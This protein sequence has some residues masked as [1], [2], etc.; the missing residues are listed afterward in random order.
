MIFGQDDNTTT[1]GNSAWDDET[2]G[3][4]REA[5]ILNGLSQNQR[6]KTNIYE[7][8][9]SDYSLARPVEIHFDDLYHGMM[10]VF[11]SS[12][13]EGWTIM[14][15]S[16]QDAV[17]D[18]VSTIYFMFLI[19][20]GSF[21]L[22]NI[23]TAIVLDAFLESSAQ[24]QKKAKSKR[25]GE[26]GRGEEDSEEGGGGSEEELDELASLV[27]E[28]S[29]MAGRKD[30]PV[31]EEVKKDPAKGG[32]R[33]SQ[34]STGSAGSGGAGV[35]PAPEGAAA[36]PSK[37]FS[38]LR[39]TPQRKFSMFGSGEQNFFNFKTM[40]VNISLPRWSG[41]IIWLRS[42]SSN[43][44]LGSLL[45]SSFFG[46]F[47]ILRIRFT[48][49]TG[50]QIQFR[51][52]TAGRRGG[53]RCG[54]GT[55]TKV[56]LKTSPEKRFLQGHAEN[57]QSGRGKTTSGKKENSEGEGRERSRGGRKTESR[58]EERRGTRRHIQK[59]NN[60]QSQSH[61]HYGK[62][63]HCPNGRLA[64]GQFPGRFEGS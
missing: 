19:F 15:Y 44:L 6:L 4:W 1:C 62:S 40:E 29:M 28:G 16:V 50:Q 46:V 48:R 61:D 53:S 17:H 2:Y 9:T 63:R 34:D 33:G 37:S 54:A 42:V 49:A 36:P 55:S 41:C 10:T 3:P 45:S 12:T 27:S 7:L 39:R 20:V 43:F 24:M 52:G 25:D 14:M 56:R 31:K 60:A 22:L 5:D 26:G 38:L 8:A 57:L 18:E 47:V 35:I 64:D 23:T 58:R 32:R 11:C 30:R 21:F 59:K 51:G 13:L